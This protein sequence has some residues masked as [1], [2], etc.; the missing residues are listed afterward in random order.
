MPKITI[1]VLAGLVA[2]A[3]AATPQGKSPERQVA[4]A[5]TPLPGP[6]QDG[7]TVYGYRGGELGTLRAGDNTMIC[8]A[9][10]PSDDRWHVACYHESLDPFMAK[11]RAL[12]AQGTKERATIDALREAAI[13]SGQL[14]MPERAAAL[15]SLTGAEGSFD[16]ASGTVSGASAL[17]V[18]YVPYATEQTIGIS[19]EPSSERPW[20]M[21][22]G[23]AWAHIM[24]SGG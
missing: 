21:L 12:R 24:I 7:A 15:Y 23:K 18:I 22:P 3:T 4:E 5:V 16:P 20:L 6:L 19:T 2:C 17:Y 9:D 11:G 1:F 8:L 14:K 10:D 13:R